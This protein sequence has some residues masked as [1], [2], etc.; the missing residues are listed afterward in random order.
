MPATLSA[1]TD[2]EFTAAQATRS[3]MLRGPSFLSDER[4]GN[5]V[6]QS[7]PVLHF[8]SDRDIYAEGDEARSFYKVVSGAV[9]TCKL[10]SDGRRQID[11]FHVTGY[12]FGFETSS[13]HRLS[14]EAVS[15][16]TV[17][18]YRRRGLE[19][20][21]TTDDRLAGQLFSYAMNVW[22]APRS[23]LSCLGAAAQHRSL[24]P[25]CFRWHSVHPAV[26]L[27]I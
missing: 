2:S 8:A 4:G 12:V 27:S 5:G 20:L 11:A 7:G 19:T 9:R 13:E 18:P 26:T 16:C 24:R 10:L 1:S 15:D 14:A 22:S 23:I 21:A 25:S 17:I 6:V 3:R